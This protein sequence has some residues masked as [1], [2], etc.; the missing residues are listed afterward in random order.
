VL[1]KI[2]IWCSLFHLWR[3]HGGKSS[4][5]LYLDDVDSWDKVFEEEKRRHMTWREQQRR[6]EIIRERAR[7]GQGKSE[8]ARRAIPWGD[9]R[10]SGG[11][12]EEDGGLGGR[13]SGVS[14]MWKGGQGLRGRKKNQSLDEESSHSGNGHMMSTA[15]VKD[16]STNGEN[17]SSRASRR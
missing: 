10:E 9:D 6:V 8:V 1:R 12:G 4:K 2:I 14:R 13:G 3:R 11:G 5:R 15:A 7:D 16:E 17:S